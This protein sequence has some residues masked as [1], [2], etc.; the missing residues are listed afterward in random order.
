LELQ[1]KNNLDD[2]AVSTVRAPKFSIY[3][4]VGGAVPKW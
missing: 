2:D 3:F 1:R 4:K